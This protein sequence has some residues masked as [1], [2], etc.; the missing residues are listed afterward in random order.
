MREIASTLALQ[1]DDEALGRFLTLGSVRYD[2]KALEEML[3]GGKMGLIRA[4]LDGSKIVQEEREQAAAAAQAQGQA[5]GRLEEARK[6]LRLMLKK[7]GP[8]LAS[9]P[10]ID[11][12][13]DIGVLESLGETALDADG[14]E[15]IRAAILAATQVN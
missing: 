2:R 8:E 11:T 12:I 5:Q 9:M 1:E 7:H 10:E 15:A 14:P 13:T 3:G 6:F 4:I